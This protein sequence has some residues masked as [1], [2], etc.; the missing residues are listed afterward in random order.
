MVGGTIAKEVNKVFIFSNAAIRGL[1]KIARSAKKN[2]GSTALALFLVSVLPSILN[3]I[4]MALFADEDQVE[5]YLHQPHFLR[6]S[7]YRIPLGHG[8]LTI[9][10]PFELGAFGSIFQ[11][12]FDKM[13]LG[14]EY[15]FDDQFLNSIA[16]LLTP[17]DM[18]GIMGGYTGII[19][20][21]FN[22]D[23]FRQ[24]Y[25]VPPGQEKASIASRNTTYA[26]KF[27][28][29]LQEK[30]DLLT[31]KETHYLVDPRK[32]DALITGQLAYYGNYF[33]N[34]MESILPGASQDQFRFDAT[35]T[36]LWRA[37]PVY[38]S[39]HVQ[40]VLSQFQE[41]PWLKEYSIYRD[42]NSLLQVYFS[43]RTQGDQKE[44]DRVGHVI[45]QIADI[46]RPKLEKA[47]LYK[48]DEAVKMLKLEKYK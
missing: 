20:T 8:F 31:K 9:P 29:M 46:W 37:A 36:G 24:K 6:D 5:E 3:S 35:D 19:A 47:N 44:I 4:L 34:M 27:G 12:M 43:E 30:S 42:F 26:S 1:D 38:S 33:L 25:I 11:R 23:L 22:K 48:V 7:F 17:Y 10:K 32:I 14:D 18:A 16:H 2:P 40:Y 28:K 21:V 41:H 45:R 39:P 13:L 15:A